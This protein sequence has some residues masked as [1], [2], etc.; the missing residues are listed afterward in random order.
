MHIQ[1]PVQTTSVRTTDVRT[2]VPG[3]AE[4]HR[5]VEPRSRTV[6]TTFLAAMLLCLTLL[7]LGSAQSF[8]ILFG[9]YVYGGVWG[10]DEPIIAAE[11]KIGRQFDIVHWF[12][13]W[14]HVWD[15]HLA[16]VAARNGR[17]PLISWEPIEADMS[18]VAAGA[19]DRYIASWAEGVKAFGSLVYLRPM[20]E[21]N[22]D[23]TP[24][25]G[26]PDTFKRAWRRM[27]GIFEQ[28]EADNVRWV[29]SPNVTDEPATQ[30]NRMENYYPGAEYVDVLALDGY[31]W[32]TARPWTLW[33]TFEEVFAQGYQRLEALGDQPIWFAE[34]A[35]TEEGGDKA[36]WIRE[37]LVSTTFQRLGA[38]VWFH[39][40]KESD[41]RMDSSERALDAFREAFEALP[42]VMESQSP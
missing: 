33:L 18:A 1:A 25:N 7:P 39:E 14:D 27:V 4:P 28:V 5:R 37:M 21:M 41:W 17:I 8:D 20:P 24:W 11:T 19:Y 12:M 31:N 2:A 10:G 3:R 6:R 26:D 22:G 30:A 29:W 35:T 34:V 38:I 15:P 42:A 9:S 23:W 40:S 32:G 36:T 16:E 13:S